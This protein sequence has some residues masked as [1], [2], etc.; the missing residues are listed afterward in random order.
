MATPISVSLGFMAWLQDVWSGF[1]TGSVYTGEVTHPDSTARTIPTVAQA[2]N[3]C[4]ASTLMKNPFRAAMHT[5]LWHCR[6]MTDSA[7][8]SNS[9]DMKFRRFE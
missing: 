7:I 6:S 4:G 8:N 3:L 2:V 1:A 5:S 9:F